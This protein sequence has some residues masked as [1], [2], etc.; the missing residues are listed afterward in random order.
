MRKTY[1]LY[2]AAAFMGI[3]LCACHKEKPQTDI[4]VKKTAPAKP[5]KT[6]KMGDYSQ[7]RKVEW[8]GAE[9]TITID[10]K[11]DPSLPLASEGSQKYYDNR[12]TLTIKRADGSEVVHRSFVKTDFAAHLDET[13]AKNGALVGLVFDKVADDELVFA[14]SVGSPDKSSDE[15]IPLTLKVDRYGTIAVTKATQL[16]T[17]AADASSD[18]DDGV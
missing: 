9:Y 3:S 2:M 8:L 7:T 4:I 12:I 10:F 15:Y 14:T 11:A 17:S 13:Y 5:S 1:I 16:D 18:D 6:L